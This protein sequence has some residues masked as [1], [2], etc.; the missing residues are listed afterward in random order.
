[1]IR[2][3]KSLINSNSARYPLLQTRA[4]KQR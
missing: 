4:I 3:E 2:I 1:M